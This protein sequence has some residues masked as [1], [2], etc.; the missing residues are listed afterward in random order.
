MYAIQYLAEVRRQGDQDFGAL[1]THAHESDRRFRVRL[2]LGPK[3]DI[4][5]VGLS[6]PS[7]RSKSVLSYVNLLVIVQSMSLHVVA[8]SAT[9][10]IVHTAELRQ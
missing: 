3:D 1:A 10:A 2:G 6:I 8:I 4:D 7:R 9:F 5:T